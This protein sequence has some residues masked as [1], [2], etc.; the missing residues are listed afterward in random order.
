MSPDSLDLTMKLPRQ[1]NFTC[2]R[3]NLFD[4]KQL[5]KSDC[6]SGNDCNIHLWFCWGKKFEETVT[7]KID[8]I[9]GER[10][11]SERKETHYQYVSSSPFW[12]L[13]KQIHIF[14]DKSRQFYWKVSFIIWMIK[15]ITKPVLDEIKKHIFS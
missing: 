15:A 8:K 3:H 7:V 1:H 2:Q 11:Y 14:Q 12:N 13:E 4:V 5:T 6:I 10:P 9:C